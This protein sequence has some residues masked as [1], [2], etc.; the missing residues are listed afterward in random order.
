MSQWGLVYSSLEN[1]RRYEKLDE[2]LDKREVFSKQVGPLMVEH[3]DN[4]LLGLGFSRE[5]INSHG[6]RLHL[7]GVIRTVQTDAVKGD[8]EFKVVWDEHSRDLVNGIYN[9]CKFLQVP[10]TESFQ[11]SNALGGHFL[12]NT[13]R[14]REDDSQQM[15]HTFLGAN[16]YHES[17][18]VPDLSHESIDLCE[19]GNLPVLTMVFRGFQLVFRAK[20]STIPNAGYGVF[21]TAKSMRGE[22]HFEL[23]EGQLLDIGE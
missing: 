17:W 5:W 7:S 12:D 16:S 19:D 1:L 14:G 18:L 11:E 15:M 20:E 13:K 6:Q 8:A 4:I 22:S 3:H 9:K 10:K 23:E 21:V 2:I